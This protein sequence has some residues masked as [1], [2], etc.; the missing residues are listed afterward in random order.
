MLVIEPKASSCGLATCWLV[1]AKSYLLS[2][3]ALLASA[4]GSRASRVDVVT[5]DSMSE[6]LELERNVGCSEMLNVAVIA[7][8]AG[9]D[10]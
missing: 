1:V 2:A 8:A 5:T 4:E 9:T 10:L 6:L 7:A 3:V